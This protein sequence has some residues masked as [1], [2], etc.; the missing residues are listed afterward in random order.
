MLH[1]KSTMFNKSVLSVMF[2]C[3][4][5]L[6]FY[7]QFQE[8]SKQRS[9][10][11]KFTRLARVLLYRGRR[12]VE[13]SRARLGTA[14]RRILRFTRRGGEGFSSTMARTEDEILTKQHKNAHCR[15]APGRQPCPGA[16]E[17]NRRQCDPG[18]PAT[19]STKSD[20]LA[21]L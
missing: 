12:K 15:R 3:Y 1:V 17:P 13:D 7:F 18:C 8:P 4:K 9:V 20:K 5:F 14:G 21:S 6:R 10:L 11:G 19:S 2:S 16:C